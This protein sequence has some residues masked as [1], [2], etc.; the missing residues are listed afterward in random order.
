MATPIREFTAG[1]RIALP[2][3]LGIIPFG[4]VVGVTATES[5]LPPGLGVAISAIV[6]AG[7]SQLA[8]VQLL[9]AAAA[10][11]VIVLTA[12][13][14]NLRFVMYSAALEPHVRGIR[15]LVRLSMAYLLTDQAFAISLVS[16]SQRPDRPHHQWF[17]F[18]VALPLFAMWMITTV[19][20]V[21]AGALVPESWGLG[22][23]VA[24]VFMA[25][26]FPAV[27]DRA[28][29]AAAVA[30]GVAALLADPLPLNLGLPI[31]ALAG[32]ATGMI[33]EGRAA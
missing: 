20:G 27:T 14:I 11:P 31:A 6:F 22:F 1:T 18:G 33:A 16:W 21:Y 2:V 30:A 5:G 15:R 7:A 12:L 25:L 4:L 28:S 24:L 19:I 8:T 3:V 10:V 26:V 32:I 13:V 29:A 23:A 17:Y 9:D